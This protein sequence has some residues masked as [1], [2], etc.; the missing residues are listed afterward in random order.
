MNDN[1]DV[2]AI[3]SPKK[4]NGAGMMIN[5]TGSAAS[6]QRVTLYE[7]FW[8]ALDLLVLRGGSD[9]FQVGNMTSL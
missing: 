6:L 2:V 9:R 5:C 3:E 4:N 1:D 8:G 7:V